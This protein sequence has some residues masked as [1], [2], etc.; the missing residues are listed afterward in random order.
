MQKQVQGADSHSIH[1]QIIIFYKYEQLLIENTCV[2]W[3]AVL[4]WV[5]GPHDQM[6]V[7]KL[8]KSEDPELPSA[9]WY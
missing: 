4:Y 1:S 8:F 7:W 2:H 6:T 3:N 5:L 9:Q